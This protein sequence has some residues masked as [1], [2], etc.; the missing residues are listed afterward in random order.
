MSSSGGLLTLKRAILQCGFGDYVI[1]LGW[2]KGEVAEASGLN[3]TTDE[4]MEALTGDVS[5]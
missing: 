4:Q 5:S 3:L 2:T 1:S